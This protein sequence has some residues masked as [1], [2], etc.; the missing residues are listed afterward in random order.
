MTGKI[1]VL[2]IDDSAS[3]RQTLTAVLSA[4]PDIEVIGAASDPFMAARKLREEIP[5]VITLDVEMPQMD[6]ITFL[7]KL[8]AQHPIPVVM[9]SSLTE[10]GSETLMQ[11]LEA[12]AVDVILKPKIG[13]A[14]HL[15]ESGE[16][17][18]TAVK[19]AARARV[20]RLRPSRISDSG[21]TAKLTADAMLPPPKLG[22]MAKTTEMVVCVGASTGGTEALRELLE[23][24]PANSPGLVIV[25]HMPEKFTAAFAKRLNSLCEVEVKEAAEGDPVL[26]GHV[27]I[28]P[29]DK[30]MLLERRGA[31]YEVSVRSGPLVSRHRPSVD[32]LFRSAA[33]SA[34]ANAMGVIMTGMGDD[35][36]RGMNEMHQAGAYT[37]AQDEASSV[38]FGMPKEAI[39]HGGVDKVVSLEQIAR[40]ILA[41][42]RRR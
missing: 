41:A 29:G 11:A 42:D 2:I 37:V 6:G 26:R 36:A 35:G 31:R 24:L 3:V 40:E 33:R 15:A 9:C 32:V 21:T 25:Q 5:D 39:A 22:A 8:M 19:G 7:R 12:G 18:R 20:G 23:A 38:V 13:A 14:D 34:G 1:R 30:H 28:A 16:R 17:I 4:D 10:S 27:L